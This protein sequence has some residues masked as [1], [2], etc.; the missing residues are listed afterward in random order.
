M[1]LILMALDKEFKESQS[2]HPVNLNFKLSKQKTTASVI[3]YTFSV[4]V[5]LYRLTSLNAVHHVQ[6]HHI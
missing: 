1:H 5:T 2:W 4:R 3:L 6:K